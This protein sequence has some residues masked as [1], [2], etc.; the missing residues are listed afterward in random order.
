MIALGARARRLVLVGVAALAAAACDQ[1]P[2]DN[3]TEAAVERPAC[4]APTVP[5][6][7]G[8][9]CGLTR[10]GWDADPAD[11][12]VHAYL[13]I[14][15]ATARRWERPEPFRSDAPL[16]A[17][18][19][20][21]VCPQ[22]AAW[23]DPARQGEDCLFLNV[24]TPAARGPRP[25]PV[26]VFI[27]GGAFVLGAGSAPVNDGGSLAARGNVVVVTLN[28]RL[29][30]LGFLAGGSGEDRLE[31]NYG[32][33][34]QQM[35]LEWVRANAHAF[36]GDAGAV[37]LFGESAG[38]MSVGGHLAAPSSRSLFHSVIVQSNP[39]GIPFKTRREAVTVRR[40]FD[41]A[42]RA[43]LGGG[44][45][46]L[47]G[48]SAQRIGEAEGRALP[49]LAPLF[50][51]GWAGLLTW[52][53]VV[54]GALVPVQPLSVEIDVPVIAGTNRDEGQLFVGG[55]R[56][57]ADWE[58][59]LALRF[60]FGA[61]ATARILEDP[62]YA[63]DTDG[64]V[65]ALG[66]VVSDYVFACAT[67]HVLGRARTPA[68]FGY[69]FRHAPSYA[70]WPAGLPLSAGCQPEQRRACHSFELPFVFGNAVT[71]VGRTARHPFAVQHRFTPE[72][73]QLA[74]LIGRYWTAF[75]RRSDPNSPESP[76][77]PRFATD[78]ARLVLDTTIAETRDADARCGA[79]WDRIGY[80]VG[81]DARS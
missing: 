45:A 42:T 29:G 39:Y 53:P 60:L 14:R 62:R 46:C 40:A 23:S 36:N 6:T 25:L 10:S 11:V 2:R 32:L 4:T 70:P 20:G 38:A 75:A 78:G 48:L 76:R 79:L 21:K 9:V 69:E 26:M 81:A 77:W 52:T 27:H 13:G 22:L 43:C 72:E 61:G 71:V 49:R 17:T 31:G 68:A 58:Y 37:T 33:R 15:Y 59:P 12:P 54:D 73:R 44:L 41:V 80:G 67:R 24:W 64:N 65:Q 1:A 56:G 5:T 66:R 74:D 50:F 55:L 35:A 47:K 7:S 3:G 16:R 51:Q 34:D 28:Y 8:P 30:A 63:G 18:A 19:P 57:L